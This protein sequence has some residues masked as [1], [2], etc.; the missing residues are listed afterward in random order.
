MQSIVTSREVK[1]IYDASNQKCIL[2]NFMQQIH[3]YCSKTHENLA[4]EFES[5]E[6]MNDYEVNLVGNVAYY[7]EIVSNKQWKS[8]KFHSLIN[9]FDGFP[10]F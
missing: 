7:V 4:M 3:F 10:H 5:I 9:M 6:A 8:M 2:S 1:A